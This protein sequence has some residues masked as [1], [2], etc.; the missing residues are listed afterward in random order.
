MRDRS[1]NKKDSI[2]DRSTIRSRSHPQD[3]NQLEITALQKTIAERER[4]LRELHDV[5]VRFDMA[6]V[7]LFS[8][9]LCSSDSYKQKLSLSLFL[10]FSFSLSVLS[11]FF[12]NFLNDYFTTDNAGS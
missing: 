3:S 11:Q 1:E 6:S 8:F 10:A 4:Q 9:D 12:V 5:N 2:D 7:F